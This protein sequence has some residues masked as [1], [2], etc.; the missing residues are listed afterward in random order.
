MFQEQESQW[1]YLK[2]SPILSCSQML[3]LSYPL[4]TKILLNSIIKNTIESK[5]RIFWLSNTIRYRAKQ[6]CG[7][8]Q[9]N[10]LLTN[11]FGTA[12]KQFLLLQ[13]KCTQWVIAFFLSQNFTLE[14][15]EMFTSCI[16]M[17]DFDF[18]NSIHV[19]HTHHISQLYSSSFFFCH[20]SFLSWI[21]DQ[22]PWYNSERYTGY[23]DC[24]GG[25]FSH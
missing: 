6:A 11:F 19:L 5:K 3:T 1:T 12:C 4:V 9:W 20:S 2:L 14:T 17:T 13:N 23:C 15:K 18:I 24:W 10:L 8:K 16:K 25:W 7:K 22:I 21:S